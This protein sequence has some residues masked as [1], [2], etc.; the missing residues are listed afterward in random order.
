LTIIE[1]LSIVSL[2][3][4]LPSIEKHTAYI[5]LHISVVCWS[6]TAILGALI[7]LSAFALVWWRV[8]LAA[9]FLLFVPRLYSTVRS[10]E[11]SL[12]RSYFWIGIL[13]AIHWI[14]FYASIKL[15]NA[16]IALITLATTS[17]FTAILEPW[18]LSERYSRRDLMLGALIIP[19]MFLAISDFDSDKIFAFLV[20]IASALLL[21][22][23][24]I[25]NRK[26]IHKSSPMAITMIEMTSAW[27]FLTLISPMLYYTVDLGVVVPKDMDWVYLLFLTLGCTILPYVLHLRALKQVAAFSINLILNLEPV[28]GIFLAIIILKE[29]KELE[30]SF[31][32]GVLMIISIVLIYPFLSKSEDVDLAN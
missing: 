17:L 4:F 11:F 31:Y 30:M 27:L 26:L 15:G 24:T 23:L 2:F 6:F 28:Y 7:D 10:L 16:S 20:G 8:L 19:A 25:C 12:L 5:Y 13:I 21:A 14:C 29:Q 22:Y 18:L 1:F 9:V 32:I 3:S